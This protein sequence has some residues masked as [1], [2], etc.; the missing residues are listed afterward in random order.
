MN[1][2]Q[3]PQWGWDKQRFVKNMRSTGWMFSILAVFCLG[4]DFSFSPRP[5]GNA[6]IDDF[7]IAKGTIIDAK[8]IEKTHM[9]GYGQVNKFYELHV[10][11]SSSQMFYLRR[12][13]TNAQLA[14]YLAA[15]PIGEE[16]S[17]RYFKDFVGNRILDV[18]NENQIFVPFS[19]IM[20]DD[21]QN[22]SNLFVATGIFAFLGAIGFWI[23]WGKQKQH[24]T[25]KHSQ[26]TGLF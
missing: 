11:T 19:E 20:A 26:A 2:G 21:S 4:V 14:Q 16:V 12:P 9:S 17:I 18:R 3:K 22:R 5:F 13:N 10:N 8:I 1:D 6:K 25:S 23:S 15:L 24:A 7:P